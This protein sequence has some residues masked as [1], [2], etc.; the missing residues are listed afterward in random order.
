MGEHRVVPVG[1]SGQ[2]GMLPPED[3]S[4]QPS[5]SRTSHVPQWTAA[6]E[7]GTRRH[8]PPPRP[9]PGNPRGHQ[10]WPQASVISG[11]VHAG[12]HDRVDAGPELPL[13]W[14]PRARGLP[15][16]VW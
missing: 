12:V 3:R 16:P 7:V 11:A 5:T 14:G 9:P 4:G 6:G 15:S 2:S 1:R 10:Q 8:L 13:Q